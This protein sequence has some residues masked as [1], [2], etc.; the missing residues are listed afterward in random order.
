M[1]CK[2]GRFN[3]IW[4]LLRGNLFTARHWIS[5]WS[6]LVS[7]LGIGFVV[8]SATTAVHAEAQWS[9][10][11]KPLIQDMAGAYAVHA[12]HISS[13]GSAAIPFRAIGKG[14]GV[15]NAARV[16]SALN[17]DATAEHPDTDARSN[18]WAA[19]GSDSND[20]GRADVNQRAGVSDMPWPEATH[21]E[22]EMQTPSNKDDVYSELVAAARAK[23]NVPVLIGLNV[24]EVPSGVEGAAADEALQR[25]IVN[26]QNQI[27]SDLGL[28]S[29][30][31]GHLYDSAMPGMAL[32]VDA[33]KLEQLFSHPGV[34]YTRPDRLREPLLA[35]STALIG[36]RRAWN[37]GFT[38]NGEVVAIIDTGVDSTHP[39]LTGKVISEACYSTTNDAWNATSVCP[40]G[41]PNS[42][43]I[44][45][46]A[47]CTVTD[48]SHG[49]HVAG[50]VANDA[51][52]DEGVAPG[53][54]ILAIQVFSR[55]TDSPGCQKID[56]KKADY[57]ECGKKTSPCIRVYDSNVL[58]ALQRVRTL[59]GTFRI[60]AVNLSL[61][62]IDGYTSLCNDVSD[63][64][65]D[66]DAEISRLRSAGIAVVIA[67]GNEE[68]TNALSLPA[69]IQGA[70]SVGS[71]NN[72]G[73]TEDQVSTSYSNSAEFLD[74]LAP[75]SYI[76]STLP[77]GYWGRLQG[78]SMA[79]P[80]VAGAIAVLRQADANATVDDMLAA[81]K[82]TGIS[83]RDGRNGIVKPRIQL[84]AAVD[85]LRETGSG[86]VYISP[87]S[88]NDSN[89]GS[90][91]LPIQTLGRASALVP[92]NGI[93]LTEPA[94]F[95]DPLTLD[96]PMTV[97]SIQGG[98]MRPSSSAPSGS[99][100]VAVPNQAPLTRADEIVAISGESSVINVLAND[101]DADSDL[102]RVV[103][104]EDPV[105]GTA[106]TDGLTV[107]YTSHADFAG[108]DE[109]NYTVSDNNG[110]L[111]TGT[112][113]VYV[114]F[115]TPR[116]VANPDF[117]IVSN[118]QSSVV[119]VLFND[120]DPNNSTLSIAA[121]TSPAH[122]TATVIGG[123]ITYRPDP[124][125]FVGQDGFTYTISDAHGNTSTATVSLSV[126]ASNRAN[127]YL[128]L[129]AH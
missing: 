97:C 50:I 27:V 1:I 110:G 116:I 83:I 74:L 73:A 95:R 28:S 30:E 26:A 61:G 31:I 63:E 56:P 129:I 88:G 71:T 82:C 109:F 54:D 87:T 10:Q 7:A 41:V 113:R 128:P 62:S 117:Y 84:D 5:R 96:D 89:A 4:R 45:S 3:G 11:P 12:E 94:S 52:G 65:R 104:V 69:C 75:G 92:A 48:C 42:T 17:A 14:I 79:A 9:E 47:P 125:S 105:H 114:R 57:C 15:A 53:A 120:M 8:L 35:Q 67:S 124:L 18:Q 108:L 93:I 60:A 99:R 2:N 37:A 46:G 90:Y 123:K 102:L 76:S 6:L 112:V 126:V 118:N 39:A 106:S 36:A 81:L 80:H 43:D 58:S 19:N 70:I 66:Y 122:G 121:V 64:A 77:A 98:G 24:P 20:G 78:T 68:R 29:S 86:V 25:L 55:F 33:N 72:A 119:D 23:G 13:H 91:N 38:G 111:A 85:L 101:T 59:N 127:I 40:E 107:A 100:P 16:D 34:K 22:N 103:D 44:G 51:S 115:S 21:A 32:T 49:T